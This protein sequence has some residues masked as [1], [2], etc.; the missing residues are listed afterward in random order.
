MMTK[1][2]VIPPPPP[3]PPPV[4]PS[5]QAAHFATLQ[6]G[7][8]PAPPVIRQ[9]YQRGLLTL[10][11]LD[12]FKNLLVFARSTVEGFFSGKHKSPFYGSSAEFTDYKEYVAGEDIGHLDWRVYGR[13]RRLYLRQF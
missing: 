2:P 10:E 8:V 9:E 1:P 6:P 12:R 7:W 4:A 5:A 13:T 3:I 11:E